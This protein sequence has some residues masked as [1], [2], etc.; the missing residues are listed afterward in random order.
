MLL[1]ENSM[2]GRGNISISRLACVELIVNF[3]IKGAYYTRACIVIYTCAK[4]SLDPAA[5][6]L[7]ALAGPALNRVYLEGYPES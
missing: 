2:S 5:L 1:Y 6:N 7:V 3:G 4:L